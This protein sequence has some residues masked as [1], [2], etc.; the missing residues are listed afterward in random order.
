MMGIR[1]FAAACW[2]VVACGVCADDQAALRDGF[3]N[4]PRETRLETWWHWQL[5]HLTKEGITADLESMR[6][7][8]IRRAHLFVNQSGGYPQGPVACTPEWYVFFDHAVKEAKRCGIELGFHNCPGWSS[9]GGPWIR[10]E[11]SMKMVT[12]SE[13]ETSAPGAVKLARPH[14]LCGF[15]RELATFALKLDRATPALVRTTESGD[16]IDTAAKAFRHERTFEFAAPFAPKYAVVQFAEPDYSFDCAIEASADDKAWTPVGG[17]WFNHFNGK[18][19][20]VPLRLKD[21]PRGSRFFRVVVKKSERPNWGPKGER[22]LV[23]VTFCD[24]PRLEGLEIDD[25]GGMNLAYSPAKPGD[26]GTPRSAFVDVTDR[27]R[28]D[29]TIDWDREGAWRFIRLGVTTTGVKNRPSSFT[30]LEC[31]KLSKRGIEAHWANMPTEFKRRGGDTVTSVTIDSFEVGE[32]NW[33][34]SLPDDFRRRRGYDLRPFLPVFAGYVVDSGETTQRFRYDLARTMSDLFAENYFGRFAELAAQS[35]L[36]GGAECTAGP[37]DWLPCME[38]VGIP[39]GEFW[40]G[41]PPTGS[42]RI[43]A[44]GGHLRGRKIIAAESFTSSEP[45]SGWK[46]TPAYLKQV[47]DGGWLNGINRFVMHSYLHQPYG[48]AK[49]GVSMGSVGTQFN[50]NLTWW[51]EGLEW[52][53]FV[54]R[55]QFLLQRGKPKADVLVFIGEGKP[56]TR[57][58]YPQALAEA[59]HDFDYCSVDDF[60]ALRASGDG[61]VVTPG[62]QTYRMLHLGR[63]RYLSSATLR[64]IVELR[65]G[66]VRMAGVKPLD[67]P[68]LADDP[69]AWRKKAEEIWGNPGRLVVTDEPA[70]AASE[71]GLRPALEAQGVKGLGHLR[72]EMDGVVVYYICDRTGKGFEGE[73]SLAADGR[74]GLELWN[75]VTREMKG[76]AATFA[77]G[78]A[79]FRLSLPAWGSVFAVIGLKD[80]K[81]AVPTPKTVAWEALGGPWKVTFDGPGAPRGEV[82]FRTLASWSEQ[83]DPGIRYFSGHATYVRTFTSDRLADGERVTLDLGDVR[84]IATVKLNGRDLGTLW[85]APFRVDI[86]EALEVGTNRLEVTVVNCWPNR[87]IGDARTRKAGKVSEPRRG[88]VPEW[89]LAGKAESGNGLYTWTNWWDA[90]PAESELHPAGLLG[91]VRFERTLPEKPVPFAVRLGGRKLKV[92]EA[93][94]S[95]LP[96][97][98]EWPGYQRPLWQSQVQYFVSFDLEAPGELTIETRGGLPARPRRIRPLCRANDTRVD[99]SRLAVPVKGPE[100]FVIEFGDGTPTNL[101][102]A[103]HV[104]VNRPFRYEHVPNEIYFGPGEHDAGLIMPTNGQTVCL[105]EGAVVYGSIFVDGAEGVRIVGRGILDSSKV[106]RVDVASD[107]Y[108]RVKA[109]G[110]AEGTAQRACTNF[111]AFRCRDLYVEGVIFRDSPRW[112]VILRNECDGAVLENIKLIGMWRYNADG[113]DVCAS[114]NVTIR[115]SF[116]RS[117]DDCFVARGVCLEGETGP[118]E[119]VTVENC[120][121]WCDWGKCLEVWMG[122]APCV[123]RNVTCRKCRL[124]EVSHLACDVT[125]WGSST[126]TLV[127]NVVF[128]DLDLDLCDPRWA[129]YNEY[130]VKKP[131]EY[132]PVRGCGLLAVTMYPRAPDAGRVGKDGGK[133]AL[134]RPNVRYRGIVA[135]DFRL[136]DEIGSDCYVHLS[137][138]EGAGEIS[139]VT[140]EGLPPGTKVNRTGNVK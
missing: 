36:E 35:G 3:L 26:A 107:I 5:S 28:A 15:Y 123:V 8:E 57:W 134:P 111:Q 114:R 116:V 11:D 24:E 105:A 96:L 87:M 55:S 62:G 74:R 127:E 73:V 13:T 95:A 32:Q 84:E 69:A 27:L 50:G 4:P 2:A 52:S 71:F 43:A 25:A 131:F 102:T 100:Q 124:V 30:G 79:S 104:F 128:S 103:L 78:R 22:H 38:R 42:P 56:T 109:R 61:G 47:G 63:D 106:S 99:G 14:A 93:R 122:S 45:M 113:I 125:C 121:L 48:Q 6:A 31:D 77:D 117:Y 68:T 98:Q 37:F 51:K 1:S 70:A 126:N 81:A 19:T 94:C 16:R 9:S 108:R 72:R 67:T 101:P 44:S 33:T 39:M 29:G 120:V 60:M 54:Q 83:A 92:H 136:H 46:T 49:P 17:A 12:W 23:G 138:P 82:T 85:F 21:I 110:H 34:E 66:G 140:L 76:V 59:G 133:R 132:K 80:A 135:K 58:W 119:N 75:P 10:P 118:V 91:P 130:K 90:W 64:K 115:D 112:S 86:T 88:N 53:R 139:D 65:A 18:A 129:T 137:M 41:R 7:M 89:V 40:P 20:P 97:N